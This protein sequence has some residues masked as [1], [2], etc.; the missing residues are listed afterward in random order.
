[1][2][3]QRVLNLEESA[4]L[5]MSAKSTAL[6]QEG[7][8]VINLSIGEPDFDTPAFIKE[9]AIK[10]INENFT[11]YTAVPGIMELRKAIC[12]KLLRDNGVEYKPEQIV[13]STGA[14]QAIANVLLALV[15]PGDEVVIACPYW[16]SYSELV[17]L[18]EGTPVL[19]KA[20]IEHDFKITADQLE[21]AITPKT[22]LIMLNSP[23]N[24][25]G[26]VYDKNELE[27]LAKVVE[28]HE[29]VFVLSDEIYEH[30]IFKGKHE[31]FAQFES[32]KDRVIIINGVSKGFAM[33]GWRLGFSASIQPIAKACS[34]LQG[35]ITSGTTSIAQKAAVVAFNADPKEMPE[36]KIMVAKFKERRDLLLGLLNDIPGV[37]TNIPDGAFYVFPDVTYFY[38]KSDGKTTIKDGKDLC[39]YILDNVFVACVPGVAFGNPNC[40]RLSYATSNENLIEAARRIKSVLANLK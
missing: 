40:I 31:C 1:M 8:D 6:K 2:I 22:K 32:I 25:T 34:K 17:K 36:M 7:K 18:A 11:H 10:A 19:V 23:C 35:Q 38:G 12:K 37:K 20:G 13:V 30:I 21:A 5:A 24:P 27:A 28:K 16:V 9:E 33:T 29:N 26:S 39:M 15:D 14:K 4:T 3:S